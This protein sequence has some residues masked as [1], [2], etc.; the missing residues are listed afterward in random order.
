M[1][2]SWYQTESKS[3][4]IFINNLPNSPSLTPESIKHSLMVIV[5]DCSYD[6]MGLLSFANN[7]ISYNCPMLF[8]LDNSWSE[9]ELI[10]SDERIKALSFTQYMH[11][12]PSYISLI[13]YDHL[14]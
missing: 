1:P 8:L 12:Q 6:S 10:E 11:L 3:H 13:Y 2:E 14:L 9:K 5:V 4:Y 7:I